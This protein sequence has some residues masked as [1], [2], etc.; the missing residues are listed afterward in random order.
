MNIVK[1]SDFFYGL[2]WV[3]KL[4]L[5]GSLQV[6]CTQE[7]ETCQRQGVRGYPTLVLFADGL[8]VEKYSGS[9]TL[10]DLV[11]F[12]TDNMAGEEEE[13]KGPV[14]LTEESFP[15]AIAEG[16][17]FVKFYAPWCG[18]CKKL[19]P[20]WEELALKVHASSPGFQIAK[21]GCV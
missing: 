12:I 13:A 10:D 17:T 14:E 2:C 16:F 9:R 8:A 5:V 20:T 1:V 7:K 4:W 18:H 19:A 15:V 11:T 6:D 3:C 21:V